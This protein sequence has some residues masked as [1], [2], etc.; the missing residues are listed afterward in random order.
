[1]IMNEF[2]KYVLEKHGND[3]RKSNIN[4]FNLP[5]Y[6]HLFQVANLVYK[7]GF[8]S[9]EN[10]SISNGH[11]LFEDTNA[12]EEEVENLTSSSVLNSIK[13]LTKD[14]SEDKKLYLKSFSNKPIDVLIIKICD[15]LCNVADFTCSDTKYAKIYFEKANI[16]FTYFT[17]RKDEVIDKYGV[18]AFD[19]LN[20]LISSFKEKLNLNQKIILI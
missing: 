18:L 16:L 7:L 20:N 4:N 1:M 12:T 3:L 19:E 14:E 15:R 13:L 8:G 11:D 5:Y 9:E 10:L 2:A 6:Y 17:S